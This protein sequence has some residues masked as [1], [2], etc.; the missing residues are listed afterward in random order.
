MPL[1]CDVY[2]IVSILIVIRPSDEQGGWWMHPSPLRH[3][4]FLEFL[5]EAAVLLSLRHILTQV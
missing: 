5:Q 1:S 2:N 3:K 4:V